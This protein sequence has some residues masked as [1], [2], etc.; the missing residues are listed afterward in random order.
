MK[1]NKY[2]LYCKLNTIKHN[3]TQQNIEQANYPTI[4]DYGTIFVKIVYEVVKCRSKII[5]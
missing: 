4:I 2:G 1:T 5:L 3:I